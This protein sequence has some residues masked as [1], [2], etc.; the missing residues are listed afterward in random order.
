M[1]YLRVGYFAS[2]TP[3]ESSSIFLIHV[4]VF[5]QGTEFYVLLINRFRVSSHFG[6]RLK[7]TFQLNPGAQVLFNLMPI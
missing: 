5:T 6:E 4:K 1:S 3:K 7:E 2:M